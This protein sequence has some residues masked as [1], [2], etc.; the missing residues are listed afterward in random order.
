MQVLKMI[1]LLGVMS[2]PLI[3]YAGG[4][5]DIALSDK[6]VR[7]EHDAVVIGSR[8]H[9]TTGLL[10]N[11][12]RGYAL[13]VGFNAVDNSRKNNE[14]I[15]GLGL[16]GFV[17]EA[18]DSALGI[19]VGLGGFVRYQPDFLWGLGVESSLY[20]SPDVI[21]FNDTESF[22]EFTLRSTYQVLPQAKVTLGW[23]SIVADFDKSGREVIDRT[24]ALGF[25]LNY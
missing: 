23:Q 6:S 2:W 7:L 1:G 21:S 5:L 12:D 15:T 8:A 20:Y 11:V 10:Y 4:S 22:Y 14:L 16:K 19:S 17:Y 9:I 18:N 24:V 25:R 3:S 13:S